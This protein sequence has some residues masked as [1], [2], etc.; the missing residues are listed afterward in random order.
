MTPKVHSK[1]FSAF[2]LL[3]P[4]YAQPRFRDSLGGSRASEKG[5]TGLQRDQEKGGDIHWQRV[6][7]TWGATQE[8]EQQLQTPEAVD[9]L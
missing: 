6:G 2:I 5:W 7:G 9:Q 8:A 1:E 3:P 4:I